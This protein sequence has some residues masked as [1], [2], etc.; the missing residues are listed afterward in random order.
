VCRA[1]IVAGPYSEAMAQS[2]VACR[3]AGL[4]AL[5]R[6]WCGWCEVAGSPPS[7]EMV[8][9]GP[10]GRACADCAD[11]AL[12]LANPPQAGQPA[13][14]FNPNVH[15]I[16]L[17]ATAEAPSRPHSLA[18]KNGPALKGMN[19]VMPRMASGLA[20]HHASHPYPFM[21][22][23]ATTSRHERQRQHG[24]CHLLQAALDGTGQRLLAETRRPDATAGSQHGVCNP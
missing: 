15:N 21:A 11:C 10:Q 23:H 13:A 1:G 18:A 2:S 4:S 3:W 20:W 16:G 14:N 8:R 5:L 24:Q 17:V 12:H 22:C 6:V 19:G 9:R 7:M